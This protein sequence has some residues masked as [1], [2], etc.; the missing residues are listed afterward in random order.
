MSQKRI[1]EPKRNT[2]FAKGALIS[3]LVFCVGT[4]SAFA[5]GEAADPILSPTVTTNVSAEVAVSE[6]KEKTPNLLPGNFFYFIKVVYENIRLSI[7]A[8]DLKEARLLAEFAQ[9]RLSEATALHAKGETEKSVQVLQKSIE[10]QQLAIELVASEAE[11]ENED[12]DLKQA[13]EVKSDLQ[14]NI[15]SLTAAL[16]KVKNPQAQKSLLKNI[17]KSFGHLEKKLAK[18]ENKVQEEQASEPL[19][20][21]AV[22]PADAN[23]DTIVSSDAIVASSIKTEAEQQTALNK[24]TKTEKD[25][26]AKETK[27]KETKIKKEAKIEKQEMLMKQKKE[28]ENNRSEKNQK[29]HN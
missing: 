17:I 29:N 22:V 23:P 3:M 15:L 16:E 25:A 9:E 18:L 7:T 4:G 19:A 28:H 6:S 11:E 20:D 27:T 26:K 10:N 2:F 8:D 24:K 5:S 1:T 13:V 12:E 21:Q 14:H